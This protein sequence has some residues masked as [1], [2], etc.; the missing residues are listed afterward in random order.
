ML[1]PN[2]QYS[3]QPDH[4]RCVFPDIRYYKFVKLGGLYQT[5]TLLRT[6]T[7]SYYNYHQGTPLYTYAYIPNT[8][9]VTHVY[10]VAVDSN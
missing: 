9:A 8:W 2:I 4:P 6:L 1:L 5:P 10:T 7:N 3:I